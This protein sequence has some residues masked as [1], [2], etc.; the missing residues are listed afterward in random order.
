MGPNFSRNIF[1]A[2]IKEHSTSLPLQGLSLR[3]RTLRAIGAPPS[4]VMAFLSSAHA[5]RLTVPGDIPQVCS[6][7]IVHALRSI[8][9]QSYSQSARLGQGEDSRGTSRLPPLL[10]TRSLFGKHAI[11]SLHFTLQQE[12]IASRPRRTRP[13]R[14]TSW[15][16]PSSQFWAQEVRLQL[17]AH[18]LPQC[19]LLLMDIVTTPLIDRM[20]SFGNA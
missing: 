3:Q 19:H 17:R 18:L 13:A 5:S 20:F 15:R 7:H 6:V 8:S 10:R 16:P 2:F 1:Q 14:W 9:S 4:Q 11:H 12:P